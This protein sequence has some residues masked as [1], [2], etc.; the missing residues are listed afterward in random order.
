ML[1]KAGNSHRC[2]V[3]ILYLQDHG[4]YCMLLIQAGVT[5]SSVVTN[6]KILVVRY[7]LGSFLS[8]CLIQLAIDNL[9][10]VSL[11]CMSATRVT[12]LWLKQPLCFCSVGTVKFN[13]E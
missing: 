13:S 10:N 7:G 1:I 2:S 11:A 5:P 6:C 12:M 4:C 3:V 8:G 9:T